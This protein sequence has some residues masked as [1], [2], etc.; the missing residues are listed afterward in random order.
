MIWVKRLTPLVLV[1]LL[2]LGYHYGRKYYE[3]RHAAEQDRL[4]LVTAKVWVATARYRHNPDQ[5]IHYRD[6]LLAADHVSKGDLDAFLKRFE[7]TP[8]DYFPFAEAV[9]VYVDSLV[10]IEDSLG[11]E[12]KIQAADSLRA[13][14][15]R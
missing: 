8:E 7:S 9:R 12:A 4:A 13:A 10:R 15:R 14:D 5:Y 2:G 6:S 3:N 1:V 11:R